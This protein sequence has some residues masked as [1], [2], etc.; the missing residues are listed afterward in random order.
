MAKQA[1]PRKEAPSTLIRRVE[2]LEAQVLELRGV[3]ARL[4]QLLPAYAPV[5]IANEGGL[6]GALAR[7]EALKV[8]W[9]QDGDLVPARTLATAWGLSPQALGVAATRDEVFSL[10]VSGKLYYP[11]EFL[12]LE[13]KTVAAICRALSGLTPA[14]KQ[15]F[16]TRAHGAIGGKTVAAALAA[17]V[18]EDRITKLAGG[19]AEEGGCGRQSVL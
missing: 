3:V 11:H 18:S 10:K 19:W 13:R 5:V 15:V 9:V 16:W 7:G 6:A 12:H 4:A 8:R 2:V 1:Q 14:K 17:G